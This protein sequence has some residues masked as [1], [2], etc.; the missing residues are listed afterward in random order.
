MKRFESNQKMVAASYQPKLHY[1]MFKA[2]KIWTTVG[3]SVL[4]VGGFALSQPTHSVHADTT[5]TEINN[6]KLATIQDQSATSAT[7]Q[8]FNVTLAAGM[9]APTW[10]A[11]DFV[12][13]LTDAQ[14]NTYAVSLSAQGLAA[15]QAVNPH[16]KLTSANIQS[17]VLTVDQTTATPDT[18]AQTSSQTSSTTQAV[19]Q[20]AAS[21]NV[22]TSNS[23]QSQSV[24]DE[25]EQTQPATGNAAQAQTSASDTTQAKTITG[26]ATQPTSTTTRTDLGDATSQQVTTAKQKASADYAA[27]KTP[28]QVTAASAPA[29]QA[30]ASIKS[31]VDRVGYGSGITGFKLT[32]NMNNVKAGDVITYTI[33]TTQT[34]N[35]HN[36]IFTL[37]NVQGF[38][39]E[40]VGTVKQTILANGNVLVTNTINQAG[41]FA[42]EVSFTQRDNYS[43]QSLLPVGDVVNTVDIYVNGTKQVGGSATFTQTVTPTADIQTPTR[44]YPDTTIKGILPNIDY[45]WELPINEDTGIL[46]DYYRASRVNSAVNYGTVITVPVPTGFVLN[47]DLT[48]QVNG[49]GDATTITQPD[50]AGGDV[51]ITVPKGSGSQYY[52]FDAA[53]RIAGHFDVA[54]SDT[55]TTLTANGAITMVQKIN[56]AGDTIEFDGGTWQDI[57]LATDSTQGA[58]VSATANGNDGANPTQLVLGGDTPNSLLQYQVAYQ[59][60]SA[61]DHATITMTVP[62]GMA[63]T[64]IVT[65]VG[66]VTSS[67]YMPGTTQ[68]SYVLTLTDGQTVSGT[69][70][71]GGTVTSDT[72]IT[73]AVFTPNYLAPGAKSGVFKLQ[74]EL[75]S[76]VSVGETFT[77]TVKFAVDTA[78][79]EKSV[80]ETLTGPIAWVDID[81][82]NS[83]TQ[84]APGE[85]QGSMLV[86]WG[87]QTSAGQNVYKI[88]E[89]IFYYDLPKA[90]AID[91]V[92]NNGNATVTFGE[93]ASGDTVVKV[94]YTGTG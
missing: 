50:G 53:Y 65:P 92:K 31:S 61:T 58:L 73:Q 91:G 40:A 83:H 49:F 44:L 84:T 54:Q 22:D 57:L 5:S 33:P 34:D 60:A 70:S 7:D 12:T 77:V 14:A 39:S 3:I 80:T 46:N 1:K 43:G 68:Y 35:L 64:K 93:S 18:E 86:V 32:V 30:T 4:F 55:D 27:T 21:H 23:E 63:V 26:N 87:A 89:P 9:T 62:D 82:N 37:D 56:D 74:G 78:Q 90:F 48:S 38:A 6:T 20:A 36:G 19:Q 85:G 47:A 72:P 41:T 13:T 10:T 52:Y 29:D 25:N 45:V 94:D 67:V 51:L 28:Q 71:A 69:V 75:S 24:A 59:S 81:T 15:L 66:G 42:Q 17:G 76:K 16:E 2:G 11:S 8:T 79:A 88:Y